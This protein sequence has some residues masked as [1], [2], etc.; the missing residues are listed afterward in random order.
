VKLEVDANTAQASVR[1]ALFLH[2]TTIRT[3]TEKNL[4]WDT[5]DAATAYDYFLS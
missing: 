4:S 1:A 5:E 2:K 3:K